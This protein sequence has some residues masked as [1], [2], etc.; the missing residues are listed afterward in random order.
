MRLS[1]SRRPC[2]VHVL[3]HAVDH[4]LAHD[5]QHGHLE[6][7]ARLEALHDLGTERVEAAAI[8]CAREAYVLLRLAVV[9]QEAQE[10][11]GSVDV[12]QSEGSFRRDRHVD[13]M[14]ARGEV[15]RVLVL[16]ARVDVSANQMQALV[17]VGRRLRLVVDLGDAARHILDDGEARLLERVWLDPHHELFHLYVSSRRLRGVALSGRDFRTHVGSR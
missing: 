4:V 16:L 1:W 12:A 17:A 3:G 5:R 14:E 7:L 9:R 10:T 15:E 11:G 8:L 2:L 13:P 6:A